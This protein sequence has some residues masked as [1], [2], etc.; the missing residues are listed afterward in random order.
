VANATDKAQN[1]ATPADQ[2]P[3]P[4]SDSAPVV[5]DDRIAAM[6]DAMIA[7][8]P[9]AGG[10]GIDNILV[11]IAQ[12]A[13]V[14][15]LDAPWRSTGL[16]ELR[17]IPIRVTAIRRIASDYAGGLPW[18]LVVDAAVRATGETVTFTT[19][20]VSVVAQLVKAW[21]MGAMP[22]DVVPRVAERASK[23]GYY[24]QHLEV[25]R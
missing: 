9:E 4:V 24:P 22:L 16:V 12:A 6:Y 15:D 13:D 20:A 3:V 5:L 14:A 1:G 17:N 10:D 23:N 11:Q 7:T 21:S 19:G 25:I 8:V 2:L 18:F